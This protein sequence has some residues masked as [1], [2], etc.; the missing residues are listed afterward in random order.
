M[1]FV[2]HI[3][4]SGACVYISW[5]KID[6]S[7]HKIVKR[8]IAGQLF[9]QF[10]L[11]VFE[12]ELVLQPVNHAVEVSRHL[13]DFVIAGKFRFGES[14]GFCDLR[15]GILQGG[16]AGYDA[17]YHKPGDNKWKQG[18]DADKNNRASQGSML[19][20]TSALHEDVRSICGIGSKFHPLSF[21]SGNI[22]CA[23]ASGVACCGFSTLF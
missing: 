15:H 19:H 2:I 8:K 11:T 9:S 21:Q 22:V 16:H 17:G 7:D 14:S 4:G 10:S 6:A 23:F 12:P 5:Y 18:D 3:K 1:L 13:R 20:I